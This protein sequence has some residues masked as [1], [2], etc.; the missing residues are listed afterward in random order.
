MN[1]DLVLAV[2]ACISVA[3]VA[4]CGLARAGDRRRETDEHVARAIRRELLGHRWEGD[5]E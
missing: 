1:A 4:L 2:W 5:D 3:A